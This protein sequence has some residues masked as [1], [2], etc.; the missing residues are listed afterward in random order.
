MENKPFSFE[1]SD[2]RILPRHKPD[3]EVFESKQAEDSCGPAILCLNPY[4]EAVIWIY[5]VKPAPFEEDP[6]T[7]QDAY[8]GEGEDKRR[9][10]NQEAEDRRKSEQRKQQR[11]R[12]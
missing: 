8:K 11:Q 7:V 9:L 1:E 10:Q 4:E 5:L 6:E 3:Y 2:E 12:I